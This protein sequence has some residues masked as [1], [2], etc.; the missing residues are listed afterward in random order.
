MAI[1]TAYYAPQFATTTLNVPGGIT[2]GQTTGITLNSVPSD[3]DIAVPWII[4]IDYATPLV[5]GKE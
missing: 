2:Y 4:C 3:I 5:T 1:P